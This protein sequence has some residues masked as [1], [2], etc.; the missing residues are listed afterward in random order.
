MTVSSS[1]GSPHQDI[2]GKAQ[3]CLPTSCQNSNF[4]LYKFV[5]QSCALCSIY[6]VPVC[7]VFM[8]HQWCAVFVR[9]S[10][11]P[12][13][14]QNGNFYL[15]MSAIQSCW[16]RTAPTLLTYNWTS[17]SSVQSEWIFV[18]SWTSS[19]TPASCYIID[20]EPWTDF[21]PR[22]LLATGVMHIDI[23]IGTLGN[24]FVPTFPHLWDIHNN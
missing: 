4:Y 21:H 5:Q 7:I 20:H 8:H 12:S 9:Q 23:G 15:P 24:K 6:V 17:Y 2:C 18:K 3:S 10:C 14:C 16:E 13:S 19:R 11:L 22:R 1:I